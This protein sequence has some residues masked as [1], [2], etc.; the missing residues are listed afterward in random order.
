MYTAFLTLGLGYGFLAANWFIGL[1]WLTSTVGILIER[2]NKEE[3]M[4]LE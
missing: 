1:T 3:A 2:L 4:L